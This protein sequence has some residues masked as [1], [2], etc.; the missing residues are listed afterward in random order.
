MN[1]CCF[2]GKV[3]KDVETRYTPN[4]TCTASFTLSV[5]NPFA[6]GEYKSDLV[7]VVAWGKQAELCNERLSKG[8]Q[9][10][11]TTR[12]SPRS[13][14]GNDGTKKYVHEF[15]I[16]QVRFLDSGNREEQARTNHDP[17][18]DDGKPIDISDDDLPF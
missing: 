17:F 16:E 5:Y 4:G 14:D 15:T 8:A 12:Y 10:A 3:I 2:V 18:Q 13:Y 1:T 9:V 11:V 7:N 6:R